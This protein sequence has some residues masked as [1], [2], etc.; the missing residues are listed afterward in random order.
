MQKKT[1]EELVKSLMREDEA[2]GSRSGEVAYKG[3]SVWYSVVASG[4][5]T[6]IKN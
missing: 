6:Y 3:H 2:V 5:Y 1:F 4:Y